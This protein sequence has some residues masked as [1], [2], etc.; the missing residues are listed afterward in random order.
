MSVRRTNRSTRLALFLLSCFLLPPATLAQTD[1]P[2]SQIGPYVTLGRG[3]GWGV[4]GVGGIQNGFVFT[5]YLADTGVC[6]SVYNNNP[7]TAHLLQFQ[8]YLTPD[9]MAVG[10]YADKTRW[11]T[12]I[13]FSAQYTIGTKSFMTF[14]LR[15]PGAAKVEIVFLGTSPGTGTPD[16]ADV[17]ISEPS[18]GC[19][20]VNGTS[21]LQGSV[22]TVTSPTQP[23]NAR[24]GILCDQS[25]TL[26]VPTATTVTLVTFDLGQTAHVC[27]YSITGPITTASSSLSF[28]P[29][30]AS[31]C[32]TPGTPVWNITSGI[33]LPNF[34]LS[35]GQGQ[36]FKG[37]I[38][39][40]LCFTNVGTGTTVTVSIGYAVF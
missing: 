7:T 27:S 17:V 39:E 23:L 36:V 32:V 12:V 1:I 2:V 4:P 34:A 11:Q 6:F 14:F 24:S 40:P 5:P 19:G 10:I 9:S 33:G 15:T 18:T 16:T 21:S 20:S 13:G 3:L 37:A 25:I 38:S 22:F 35:D 29:G 28:A 26:D 8:A 31:S 30:T